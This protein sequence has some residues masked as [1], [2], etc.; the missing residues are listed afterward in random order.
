MAYMIVDSELNI[1]HCALA[2]NLIAG[3]GL[4]VYGSLLIMVN[5]RALR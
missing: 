1:M 4:V 5:G 2:L 3:Y